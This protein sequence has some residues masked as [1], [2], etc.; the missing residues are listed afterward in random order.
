LAILYLKGECLE[1]DNP[2]AFKW[3]LLGEINGDPRGERLHA[4]CTDM[5]TEIE[6]Q[7]GQQRAEFF[8]KANS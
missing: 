2:E 7:E 1:A 4:H 5:F 8:L 6:L 3:T